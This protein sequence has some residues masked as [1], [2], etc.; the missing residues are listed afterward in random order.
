MSRIFLPL[1]QALWH[2][3][4]LQSANSFTLSTDIV[5]KIQPFNPK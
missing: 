1:I 3:A 4:I 5:F 2:E